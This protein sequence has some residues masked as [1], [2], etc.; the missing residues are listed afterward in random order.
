MS[1]PPARPQQPQ[2]APL[3]VMHPIAQAGMVA[4]LGSIAGSALIGGIAYSRGN[5][6]MYDSM[7]KARMVLAATGFGLYSSASGW[8]QPPSFLNSVFGCEP[9]LQPSKT[10]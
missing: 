4:C 5:R 10:Q 3:A 2:G 1:A 8:L 6:R 7:V 9:R